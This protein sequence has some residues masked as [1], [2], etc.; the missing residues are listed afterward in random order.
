MLR[1]SVAH[2]S[3]QQFSEGKQGADAIDRKSH[4]I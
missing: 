3:D 2:A 1:R 4:H